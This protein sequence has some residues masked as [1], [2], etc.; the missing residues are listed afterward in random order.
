LRAGPLSDEGVISVLNRFYVPVYVSNEDYEKN[1]SVSAEEKKAYMRIYHEAL[2]EKRSAGS[3]CV[4][5]VS[6]DGK[7]V[8][9]MIVS[10][11][12]KPGK[13]RA[14]LEETAKKLGTAE[15]KA[16]IAPTSQSKPPKTEDTDLVLHS[17]SRYDHRG[18]WAE[19]PAE[20]WIVLKE[21]DAKKLLPTG[22]P[23]V[24]TAWDVNADAAA[25]ILTYFFPQTE[26][27]DVAHDV[28]PNGRHKH[29]I[30]QLALRGKVLSVDGDVARAR[31]DGMVR[32]KRKFYPGKEDDNHVDASVLGYV[33]F[34]ARTQHIRVLRIATTAA[35]YANLKFSV[36]VQSGEK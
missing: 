10:E 13:L 16:L 17:I 26:T 7:G 14:L 34:D 6:P 22:A 2:K 32:I 21:A 29:Q 36:A 25:R 33:E 28:D 30:K 4:Y 5:L 15:G 20:N 24:G 1:G 23:Q 9:S 27:C 3:V 31:L 18:S 19:F 12:A 11:A 35:T 8:A